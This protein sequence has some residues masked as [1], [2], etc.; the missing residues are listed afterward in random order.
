MLGKTK[1]RGLY[2][3]GPD[4]VYGAVTTFKDGGVAEGRCQS[5]FICICIFIID[6]VIVSSSLWLL[7][8]DRL[9]MHLHSCLI[10]LSSQNPTNNN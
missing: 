5:P 9:E 8:G 6:F 2:Y 10:N 3:P 4:F 1:S 7:L